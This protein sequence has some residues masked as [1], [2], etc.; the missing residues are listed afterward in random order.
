MTRNLGG[1][2]TWLC[3]Y[4]T[5]C[6]VL[7]SKGASVGRGVGWFATIHLKKLSMHASFLQASLP[8]SFQQTFPLRTQGFYE[9]RMFSFR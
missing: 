9:K 2:V 4:V 8:A 3:G 6:C 1:Y 5:L 7:T